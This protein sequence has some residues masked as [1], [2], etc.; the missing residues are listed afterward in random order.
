MVETR[1]IVQSGQ[2]VSELNYIPLLVEYFGP[3]KAAKLLGFLAMWHVSGE[4]KLADL[5][6]R[7]VL[8]FKRAAVYKWIVQIREWGVWLRDEKG[9][10]NVSADIDGALQLARLALAE[11]AAVPQMSPAVDIGSAALLT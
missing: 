3:V 5:A 7:N 11:V 8:G 4:P 10:Q 1:E 2:Q 9:M 6:Y